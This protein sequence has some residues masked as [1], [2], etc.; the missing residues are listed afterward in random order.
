MSN[1]YDFAEEASPSLTW[2]PASVL[3]TSLSVLQPLSRVLLH[4]V[5][6]H[7]ASSKLLLP[8]P[9]GPTMPTK[10]SAASKRAQLVPLKDLKAF[11][12]TADKC[13]LHFGLVIFPRILKFLSINQPTDC[14]VARSDGIWS[15]T[16]QNRHRNCSLVPADQSDQAPGKVHC[17]NGR[18]ELQC[19]D[20]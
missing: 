1:K 13:Q 16:F 6:K 17:S 7:T 12:S 20:H 3:V 5:A 19:S 8:D 4:P 2:E 11:T 10:P 15:K 9:L 14:S 18:R